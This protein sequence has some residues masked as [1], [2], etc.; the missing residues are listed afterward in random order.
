MPTFTCRIPLPDIPYWAKR[1]VEELRDDD[2]EW[3][4]VGEVAA[5]VQ[6]DGEYTRADFLTVA[7]W[8]LQAFLPRFPGLFQNLEA[9][10][11]DEIAKATREALAADT[12]EAIRV[13]GL[14]T[15]SGVGVSVAFALLHVGT[16]HREAPYPMLDQRALW[17]L[18]CTPPSTYPFNFWWPYVQFCC[19]LVAC[20]G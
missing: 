10:S 4:V 1:Y 6:R 14:V 8:K 16:L 18:S 5:G 2:P 17:S 3:V 15:L 9:N 12:P 11:E 19:Q 13:E 20:Q 7:N